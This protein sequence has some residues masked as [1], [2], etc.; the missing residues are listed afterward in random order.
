MDSRLTDAELIQLVQDKLPEELTHAEIRQLHARLRDSS[1]LKAVLLEQ[2]QLE[3]YLNT[4]LSEINLSVDEIV[5]RAGVLEQQKPNSRWPLWTGLAGFLLLVGL[6]IYSISRPS[7]EPKQLAGGPDREGK[8]DEEKSLPQQNEN[9]PTAKANDPNLPQANEPKPPLKPDNGGRTAPKDPPVKVAE[10]KTPSRGQPTDPWYEA[11]DPDAAPQLLA[12]TAYRFPS[13]QRGDF[14]TKKEASQWLKAAPGKPFRLQEKESSGDYWVELDGVGQLQAPWVPDAV[15]RLDLFD[16]ENF[17]LHFWCGDEGVTLWHYRLRHPWIWTAYRS[18]R[19]PNQPVP[20]R[21]TQLLMTDDGR[22]DRVRSGIIEFR[23]QDGSLVVSQGQVRL[24]TIPLPSPPKQIV[25]EGKCNLSELT[26]YRGEGFPP[27]APN[28]R[29]QVLASVHPGDLTWTTRHPGRDLREGPRELG[30]ARESHD[31]WQ[32]T[33][34]EGSTFVAQDN[35]EVCLAVEKSEQNISVNTSLKR[36]GLYEVI[37]RVAE[38]DPGTCLTFGDDQGQEIY[39]VAFLRER[40]SKQTIFEASRPSDSQVEVDKNPERTTVGFFA[41]GQWIR[42]VCGFGTFKLWT[43]GDGVHWGTADNPVGGMPAPFTN[44]GLLVKKTE[45]PRKIVLERLEIRELSAITSLASQEAREAAPAFGNLSNQDFGTWNHE[46]IRHWPSSAE[47]Q[48]PFS[49]EDWRRACAIR[50]LAESPWTSLSPTLLRGL[51]EEGIQMPRPIEERFRL[52]DEVSLLYNLRDSGSALA[53]A[54]MYERCGSIAAREDHPDPFGLAFT[55]L[56]TAPIWS[57]AHFAAISPAFTRDMLLHHAYTAEWKELSS[58]AQRTEFLMLDSNPRRFYWWERD[59][60]YLLDWADA[61]AHHHAPDQTESRADW[62]HRFSRNRQWPHPLVTQLSKEGYNVMA[63]FEAALTGEAYEDACRIITSAGRA[64]MAGLLPD[65]KDPDLLVSLPRA[66]A[67]AMREHADL[68]QTMRDQF[69]D[70]G[71]VRVRE[72]MTRADVDAVEAATVRFYGTQAAAEAYRWLGNRALASGKFAQAAQAYQEALPFAENALVRDVQNRLRLAASLL[73]HEVPTEEND[74]VHI[75]SASWSGPEFQRMID[76][77][78]KTHAR[79]ET[80]TSGDWNTAHLSQSVPPQPARMQ[81]LPRNQFAGDL[82]NGNYENRNTDWAARQMAVAASGDFLFVSNRFQVVCYQISDGKTV[83]TRGLGGEQ[84]TVNQWTFIPMQPLIVG[85]RVFVRRLTKRGPE[86][87]CLSK[88]KGEVLWNVRPEHHVASDPVFVQ[89]RLLAFVV[90]IPQSG[91]L[92][93]ELTSFHPETGDVLSQQPVLHLRDEWEGHP[94]CQVLATN[95]K[96][97]CTI[98]GATLCCDPLGQPQWLQQHPWLPPEVDRYSQLQYHHP[99]LVL[100]GRVYSTQSGVKEVGCYELDTGRQ[101]WSQPVTDLLR[102]VGIAGGRLIVQTEMG[103]V[104]FD[105]TT[106]EQAWRYPMS[107]LLDGVV[108]GGDRLII[109]RIV[110]Y[111]PEGNV[112]LVWL[113]AISGNELSQTVLTTLDGKDV[114]FG[115]MIEEGERLWAFTARGF[116]EARRDFVELVPD[117]NSAPPGP[118]VPNALMKWVDDVLPK[119][120]ANTAL[121]LPDWLITSTQ[122][123]SDQERGVQLVPEFRG[124]KEVLK[125]RMR[126]NRPVYFVRKVQLPAAGPAKLKLRLGHEAGKSWTVRVELGN[127]ILL[128]QVLDDQTAPN[129]WLVHEVDLSPW[130]GQTIWLSVSQMPTAEKDPGFAFWKSLELVLPKQEPLEQ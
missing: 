51:L 37:F 72:A 121:V 55:H 114:R 13:F 24:L 113:D 123:F 40:A 80:S 22:Q 88:D 65:S 52:L 108:C 111:S 69:G 43:S 68:Q 128:E 98:G 103:L 130:A 31:R 34:T 19:K 26:M 11:L 36:A 28:P 23:Y 15:L 124:E 99:P 16:D 3:T 97:V 50:S 47:E 104:A 116:K 101:H 118:H 54:A 74:A 63:E 12:N 82:G 92:Q 115:P 21:L 45:T 125:T 105:Q 76:E 25:F 110:D 81:A 27:E 94:P 122:N 61:V 75:A 71:R 73:G 64:G 41:P 38:A 17:R 91:M 42:V 84:G 35:G 62:V 14:L 29:P 120:F 79:T 119:S 9:D 129:G 86:L 5:R 32:E 89:N 95:G 33:L 48:R 96:I 106:G 7:P 70:V 53:M 83:W 44:V 66:I 126:D 1:E 93:I 56:Q 59:E 109:S 67:I 46:V 58:V 18:Q 112:G 87:A 85:D 10:T 49:M 102:I 107:D 60:R 77:L 117:P 6:G 30:Q 20:E 100:N 90:T 2:L 4:A 8:I 57:D 78:R 127:Q 39:R